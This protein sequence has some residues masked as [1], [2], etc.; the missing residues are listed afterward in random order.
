[1]R[2][3]IT[4][5]SDIPI[6][7]QIIRQVILGIIS[8][9]LT[10]G[11]KLP[12]TRALAQRYKIHPNTVSAAYHSLCAQDWLELRRGSGLYVRGIPQASQIK[13]GLTERLYKLLVEARQL[14]YSPEE[15]LKQLTQ[16][17]EPKRFTQIVILEPDRAMGE[18]LCEELHSRLRLTAQSVPIDSNIQALPPETLFVALPTRLGLAHEVLPSGASVVALP[19][20]SISSL[21]KAEKKPPP[22]A[23]IAIASRSEEFRGTAIQVLLATGIPSVCLL[24]VD[25]SLPDWRERIASAATTIVDAVVHRDL[26]EAPNTRL[27]RVIADEGFAKLNEF[28]VQR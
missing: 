7:D 14:G 11:Q 20:R 1:V 25:P 6:R 13:D 3:W 2:F 23:L 26:P 17:V 12:S 16:I 8:E 27:F 19:V 22:N 10:V 9:D 28:V 18:I 24:P 21:L 5:N 15:V 4:K